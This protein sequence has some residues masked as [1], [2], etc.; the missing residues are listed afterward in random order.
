VQNF[1]LENR[2][3]LLCGASGFRF[4][5]V[6]A[7]RSNVTCLYFPRQFFLNSRIPYGRDS[8]FCRGKAELGRRVIPFHAIE[9]Q[10]QS[11]HVYHV[12]IDKRARAR[13]TNTSRKAP[14]TLRLVMKV[15]PTLRPSA[16]GDLTLVVAETTRGQSRV[17]S[18]R[19]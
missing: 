17:S 3:H 14:G 11:R 7:N 16:A 9:N 15:S 19:L 1:M 18:S 6:G 13:G 4:I 10:S 5:N 12:R 2:I 8:A